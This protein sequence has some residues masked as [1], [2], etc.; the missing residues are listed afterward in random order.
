MDPKVLSGVLSTDTNT[1]LQ[2]GDQLLEFIRD[3]SNNIAELEELE[4][5]IGGLANWMGSN[6]FRVSF[7][8]ILSI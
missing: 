3:E 7:L 4:T 6:N 5:L 8:Y 2:A 1:R